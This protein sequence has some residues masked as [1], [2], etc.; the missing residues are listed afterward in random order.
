MTNITKMC[1]IMLVNEVSYLNTKQ[2]NFKRIADNRTHKIVELISK[3]H[4][5]S[6][7]SFYEYTDEQIDEMFN[8]IQKELDKQRTIFLQERN[9]AKKKVEL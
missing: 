6:N 4:N 9:K 5:L 8:S 2:E 7:S 3:L 1:Y